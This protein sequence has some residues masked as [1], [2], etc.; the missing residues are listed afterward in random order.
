ML[1]L[2]Q[3]LWPN[4]DGLA[5]Q[6]VVTDGSG[7]LGWSNLDVSQQSLTVIVPDVLVAGSYMALPMTP[8]AWTLEEFIVRAR[9]GSCTL[10]VNVNGT[11]VGDLTGIA[12]T[13]SN[14]TIGLTEAIPAEAEITY[15]VSDAALEDLYTVLTYTP[16]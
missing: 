4:T 14:T 16:A 8:R 9:N 13:E 12:V 7:Q 15:S 3:H 10:T 2:D 6:A 11:P 1:K 5:G